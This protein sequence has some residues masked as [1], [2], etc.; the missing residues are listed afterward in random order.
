MV[1]LNIDKMFCKLKQEVEENGVLVKE[2]IYF[3]I[4]YLGY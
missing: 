4:I 2:I 1:S 3:F